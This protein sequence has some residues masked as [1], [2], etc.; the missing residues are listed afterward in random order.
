[1]EMFLFLGEGTP[2]ERWNNFLA[3]HEAM[4]KEL[5]RMGIGETHAML[6]PQ[7]EK[8]FGKRLESIGWV[9]E[10]PSYRFEL[11]GKAIPCDSTT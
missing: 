2:E 10:W 6:P 7:I 4:K 9:R 11:D 1:M 3:L 8:R 5:K